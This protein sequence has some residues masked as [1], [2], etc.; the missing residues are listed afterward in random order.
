M[1]FKLDKIIPWGRSIK[2][3]IGMF[4]LIPGELNLSILDCGGGPASFNAQMTRQGYKVISCDPLY[5]FSVDEIADRIQETYQTVI[6]GVNANS[7]NYVW[8][9]LE[10]PEQMG[11]IR[12]EAMNHF[13]DDFPLGLLQGRYVL[14]KLPNLS[15]KDR[16]FDLALCS[17]LLFTY[18]DHLSLDFHLSSIQELCRVA[19]EVRIFPLIN[20]SGEQSS[21]L[22]PVL[23]KLQQN[24]Y[25]A[26]V[27]QV[28][29]EFQKGGNKLLS[30]SFTDK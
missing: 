12:M 20:L 17:H 18:S 6:D 2:E 21:L 25:I 28:N 5:Q 8:H 19:K 29:Y 10:S 13:L 1:G 22:L 23:N 24:G 4:H 11:K 14:D 16:Q 7:A 27:K 3:Y 15:F 26:E 30:V 9:N